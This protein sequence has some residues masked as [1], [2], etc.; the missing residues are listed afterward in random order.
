MWDRLILRSFWELSFSQ[1]T[2]SQK[3]LFPENFIVLIRFTF[4]KKSIFHFPENEISFILFPETFFS[5]P[6]KKHF[7][8]FP[9]NLF[10][11]T[12]FSISQNHEIINEIFS[13]PRTP[14]P[15]NFFSQKFYRKIFLCQKLASQN[16]LFPERPIANILFP[17]LSFPKI[18]F[19]QNILFPE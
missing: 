18:V 8:P 6:R 4:S 9:R 10:P 16:I 15:R 3:C 5:F 17:E 7:F 12:S 1:K 11:R 13:F 2:Y 14:F 19:S